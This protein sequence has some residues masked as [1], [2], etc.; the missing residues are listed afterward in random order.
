MIGPGTLECIARLAL[1]ALFG[2]LIGLEREI[3]LKGAGVR[4]HLIV[5]FASCMMMLVSKY[6]FLD[7]LAYDSVGLDP[8]RIAAG[9]VTAIGFLGA[10]T[11]FSRSQGVT[12][13]TTA[14]GLWA[15]VG[16]GMTTGAGMYPISVFGAVFIVGAQAAL[17]RDHAMLGHVAA[18]LLVRLDDQ[19]GA[20][21]RLRTQLSDLGL[22]PRATKYEREGSVL[23]VEFHLDHLPCPIQELGQLLGPLMEQPWV[24]SVQW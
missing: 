15:T 3:R 20:L 11:I 21:E 23:C 1:S 4:T 5:S 9:I 12:G 13:L 17:H 10:G 22:S 8:S 24:K 14:A 2:G 6:G 7:M 16:I 18:V 19:P